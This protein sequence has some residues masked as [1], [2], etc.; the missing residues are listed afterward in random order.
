MKKVA[1][2]VSRSHDAAGEARRAARDVLQDGRG[3]LADDLVRRVR[4][5]CR[6]CQRAHL[7]AQL[8][9]IFHDMDVSRSGEVEYNARRRHAVD[10][11]EAR[12]AV[13]QDGVPAARPRRQ[14][15]R[16]DVNDLK[17]MPRQGQGVHREGARRD[18]RAHRLRPRRQALL[19]RL[20]PKLMVKAREAGPGAR[21]LQDDAARSPTA[22][23]PRSPSG[24]RAESR[25]P[26]CADL[27]AAARRARRSSPEA[28]GAA[29][30]PGESRTQCIRVCW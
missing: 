29:L 13:D 1:L 8:K 19:R 23:P 30:M 2:E 3:R 7:D 6:S 26:R 27:L 11:E 15:A 28:A 20:V 21:P 9:Q 12:Q 17:A 10:A 22:A 4:R 24:G 16:V 5:R 18:R 25:A 14:R